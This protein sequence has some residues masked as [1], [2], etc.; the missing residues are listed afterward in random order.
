MKFRFALS[1]RAKLLIAFM[2]VV[3]A[4]TGATIY[5]AER[6]LRENQ[7]AALNAQFE[8]QV[9]TFLAVEEARSSA[10]MERCQA[11]AHSVRLRAA[12][13]EHDTDDLYRNA[14]AELQGIL[15]AEETPSQKD[16]RSV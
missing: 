9:R 12:L 15:D 13:E 10:I 11:V 8:Y 4:I 14:L 5:F 7:Q 1:F 2:C 3:L 6:N 16:S